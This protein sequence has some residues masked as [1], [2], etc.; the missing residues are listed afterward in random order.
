MAYTDPPSQSPGGVAT[1]SLWNTYVRDNFRAYPALPSLRAVGTGGGFGECWHPNLPT[2]G[3]GTSMGSATMVTNTIYASPLIVPAGTLDR[4]SFNVAVSGGAN[5]IRHGI[6]QA[7]SRTD[8]YPGSL[9]VDSGDISV[10]T[11]GLKTTTISVV[12]EATR[13][14]W[15]VLQTSAGAPDT[16]NYSGGGFI[17][18]QGLLART[19]WATPSDYQAAGFRMTRTYAALPATF[20]AFSSATWE[21]PR[22]F[23]V[24]YSA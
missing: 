1:A 3:A 21:N 2:V 10:N 20:P 14:Y 12:I 11:T 23:G 8:P 22:A 19:T 4:M 7:A 13:L 5:N 17:V 16:T 24:R 6:Y 18:P 15:M 9:L